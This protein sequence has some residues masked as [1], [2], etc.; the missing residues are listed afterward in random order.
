MAKPKRGASSGLKKAHG[1]KKHLFK[2]LKPM[3][4]SMHQNGLLNKYNAY[5]SWCIAVQARGKKDISKAE[6]NKFIALKTCKEK[7]AYFKALKH[8]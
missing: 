3:I 8:E 5:E 7:D 1:P 6:F 2:A 4:H